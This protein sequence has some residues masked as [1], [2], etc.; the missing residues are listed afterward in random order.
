RADAV[1]TVGTRL[2]V[3]L[4]AL[5]AKVSIIPNTQILPDQGWIEA[6]RQRVR[7]ELGVPD[8]ALLI[9]WFGH[10][11][12]DRLLAPALE[13]VAALAGTWMV[14]GG[15]G[16][17]EREVRLAAERCSRILPLGKVALDRVAAFVV[18]SDVVYYGLNESEP[19]SFY[20]MPNLA[21]FA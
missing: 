19:N 14:V 20:F 12:P 10:L 6:T 9:G 3:R 17:G 18:A 1:L 21:F 5:G 11:T 15:T 2:E 16:P 4:S 13:A 7:G 8:G